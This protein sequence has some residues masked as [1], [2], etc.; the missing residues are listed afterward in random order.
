MSK[1]KL[2]Y[3]DEELTREDLLEYFDNPNKFN[4][5]EMD[6]EI[7][8]SNFERELKSK[9]RNKQDSSRKPNWDR[10]LVSVFHKTFK[11]IEKRKLTDLRFLQW[12]SVDRFQYYT[13][14]RWMTKNQI[15]EYDG[16]PKTSDEKKITLNA[17]DKE[18]L[19]F[20]FLGGKS[21][22]G[23]AS[24][25]TFGRMIFPGDLLYDE[26]NDYKLAEDL[27]IN[28]NLPVALFERE[29]GLHAETA[30]SIVSY[31]S[32]SKKEIIENQTKKLNHY[33]TTISIEGVDK[34]ILEKIIS[35]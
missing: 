14:N 35:I 9:S 30:K 34:D 24:R 21:L 25:H 10:E 20:R 11:T 15:E 8:F 7:D 13:W 23:L 5:I 33:A 2:F 6:Y 16:I 3:F 1:E 31:L 27:F 4:K 12:L 28:Q 19:S 18:G 22:K 26:N 17:T 32:K 29:F